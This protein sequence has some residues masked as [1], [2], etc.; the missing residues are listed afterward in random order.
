MTST[1]V[2]RSRAGCG[3]KVWLAV[4][5]LSVAVGGAGFALFVVP[6]S[7]EGWQEMGARL[8]A[9]IVS[10]LNHGPWWA[11]AAIAGGVL[12]TLCLFAVRNTAVRILAY[13]ALTGVPALITVAG[14]LAWWMIYIDTITQLGAQ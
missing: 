10:I 2:D 13:A 7:S 8:P 12:A 3:L 1:K 14:I 11:A 4:F 9:F 5:S 6:A